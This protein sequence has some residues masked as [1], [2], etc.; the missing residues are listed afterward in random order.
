M[1]TITNIE[2]CDHTFNPWR[3]CTKV[4][5]GCKHCYADTMSKRNPGVLGIW[6][7]HG[8]RRVAA[9]KYWQQPQQWDGD[10][11]EKGI[12]RRVFCASLADVFEGNDTMPQE[13]H[14][15]VSA[16]R[17]QLWQLIVSTPNLD[18]L[19]LTKRPENIRNML[20]AEWIEAPRHNV[21]LGTTVESQQALDRRAPVLLSIPATVRFFSA[22]PLITELN[23]RDYSPEW[24]IVG[25]E[26][27]YGARPMNIEWARSLKRQA[28]EKDLAFFMK[29]LG[30]YP[31]KRDDVVDL[32]E[33]LRIRNFPT[34]IR[35]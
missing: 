18:W 30:G 19:L 5:Q 6:G 20:P 2:W 11:A 9:E 17:N 12:R 29:Q 24:L 34:G 27:G 14:A 7:K 15:P 10:A 21:W 26:S 35:L 33:D 25:G 23:L 8:T 31:N 13:A 3:G 1:G 22:E 28:Q 4:S 32:P 16:A